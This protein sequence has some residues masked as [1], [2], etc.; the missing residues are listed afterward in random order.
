MA[1]DPNDNIAR[2]NAAATY[3]LLGELD[4]AIDLLEIWLQ[5]VGSDAKLWFGN[6]S[7]FDPIRTHPRYQTL[8]EL[9]R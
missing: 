6:D 9:A 4:R 2:Y 5:Q 8:L 1:I 3:S 7:D